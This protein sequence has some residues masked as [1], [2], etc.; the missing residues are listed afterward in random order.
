MSVARRADLRAWLRQVEDLGELQCVSGADW[1]LEIGAIAEINY[2]RKPPAAMLFDD[3]VGYPRGHRVLIG[4]LSNSHRI[5]LTLGLE[6]GLDTAGLVQALRGRPLEWER[7]AVEFEPLEVKEG[8]VLQH[9][10]D[11]RD[12]DLRQFP[13]PLWHEHDGGRYLGTGCAV[14]TSDPETG[15]INLGAYRMM[16]QEEGRSTTV[17][18][19]IG[20]QGR[21]HYERWFAREG[22][23]PVVASLGHDPLLL[24]VAGT[25]VPAS[26][27]EYAYAG[28]MIGQ[29][30]EV[31][32][33]EVTGLPIPATAE[34]VLEGWLSPGRVL[35]EGPFGEWTG[36]YSG[37]L[38]PVPTLDVAR[39]YFRDHPVLLGAPPG[40]PPNDY[41]YMRALLKSAMI[42]DALVKSGVRDVRGVWAHETGGGRLLIVVSIT[43]RFPGHSRQAGFITAQ[44]DAAAYMNRYVI[45]VDDDIDPMNLEEVMW[46]VCTR[47]DP[48]E[49]IDIMRK[50]W[51]SKVDP[52]VADASVPYNSRA[53]IDACRPFE[54]LATFP[55]VASASPRLIR[56]TVAKWRDVF[57]DP[58]FPLPESAIPSEGVG[59]L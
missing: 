15:Q 7:R 56:D 30:L 21:A 45:V 11:G 33:G 44:C 19:E 25:E 2:R 51:G 38:R 50:S 39:V 8:P 41:S 34:I 26:I 18:A 28:A 55:R 13:A 54:R 47:C 14:V 48:A 31:V 23:A 37:S 46:A 32:R 6:A 57:N 27:S 29:P 35:P 42:Q 9:V 1:N 52:L 12:F 59:D 58:R 36:Y 53:L 10:V 3:I 24:M 43:Q 5:A 4:S 17:N 16:L 40:K 20:K 49:D 22:R